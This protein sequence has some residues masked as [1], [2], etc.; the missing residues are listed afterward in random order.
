MV[1]P[2]YKTSIAP[3]LLLY[4]HLARRWYTSSTTLLSL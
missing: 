2:N 4:L 1:P 3:Q